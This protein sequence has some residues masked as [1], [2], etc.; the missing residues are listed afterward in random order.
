MR[1][2]LLNLYLAR[3]P[4]YLLFLFTAGWV[5]GQSSPVSVLTVNNGLSSGTVEC[6]LY[7]SRG[8]IWLG[9]RA[10]L[11]R[12]D[13]R[14]VVKYLPQAQDTHAI[15]SLAILRIQEDRKGRLFILGDAGLEMFD[16]VS[17]TFRFICGYTSSPPQFHCEL[18]ILDSLDIG[19]VT[20]IAPCEAV[21]FSLTSL[22][23]FR[24]STQIPQAVKNILANWW[25][26]KNPTQVSFPF[27]GQLHRRNLAKPLPDGNDHAYICF[28]HFNW[29]VSSPESDG[30]YKFSLD[31]DTATWIPFHPNLFPKTISTSRNQFF[32]VNDT[33]AMLYQANSG[34]FLVQ[35]NSGRILRQWDFRR[36]PATA[37]STACYFLFNDPA[38]R[39]WFSLLPYGVF[40]L[41]P[42]H[43]KFQ[44]LRSDAPGA[45]LHHGLPLSMITDHRGR[46][47]IG[48]YDGF[49]QAF[50]A[51]V[52]QVIYQTQ[53]RAPGIPDKPQSVFTLAEFPDG[54]IVANHSLKI[55]EFKPDKFSAEWLVPKSLIGKSLSGLAH[56]LERPVSSFYMG[57]PYAYQYTLLTANKARPFI[58]KGELP[59]NLAAFPVDERRFFVTIT[60]FYGL[61]EFSDDQTLQLELHKFPG[62]IKSAYRP[63]ASDSLWITSTR[64][65]YVY[66]LST[67]DM[68]QVDI[69]VWPSNYLYG[70]LPDE[71][72]NFWISTNAGIIRWHPHSGRWKCFD[73]LDGLQSNEFNTNCFA[74]LQD[75]SLAFGGPEGINIFDPA[76][77]RSRELPFH[78]Y[79]KGVNIHDKPVADFNPFADQF[80]VTLAPK[81]KELELEYGSTLHFDREDVHYYVQLVGADADWVDMGDKELAR[82]INLKPGN[83]VFRVKAVNADEV[84]SANVLKAGVRVKPTF[85]QTIWFLL[86][87]VLITAFFLYSLFRYRMRQVQ[88]LESIR[89]RISHDLHDDVG[90]TLGSIS[91][92]SEVAKSS[93]P[94]IR[95][96]V[97]EK[98]GDASREMLEKLNDIVWSINPENDSPE[99]LASRMRA[100]AAMVLNP[101]GIRFEMHTSIHQHEN[102]SM[103]TRRNLFLIFKEA[104]YNAAKYSGAQSVHI[105]LITEPGKIRMEIGDDGRGFD[106]G[107]KAAYNGN[108]LRSMEERARDLGAVLEINSL[109]SKGT[110]IVLR[111]V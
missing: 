97:L 77:F 104:V 58:A 105:R 46:L 69:P 1:E 80:S 111:Q 11:H 28:D 60:D 79:L 41:D 21:A 49:I 76:Y 72:G 35:K 7:D 24:D 29:W 10:G 8:F 99:K 75:G 92:Y 78:V 70:L 4:A 40:V 54:S 107:V 38:G 34:M 3:V 9:T 85:F 27:G 42:F 56:T 14:N 90:S 22:Q 32:P 108:G 36:D 110:R 109:P 55:R 98:I 67:K 96:D 23:L 44:S 50:N 2:H 43:R 87:C 64:G 83:Y 45:L 84:W 18:V 57:D 59:P 81:D 73:V 33:L 13:G 39:V 62:F 63:P 12:Y 20:E 31:R 106:P 88:K 89:N 37:K 25:I 103:D 102:L 68:T 6:G 15:R 52:N 53:Y 95:S 17:N 101:K 61:M 51:G 86:T 48:F 26:H 30:I 65:L 91:I 5:S 93:D 94:S 66:R 16:P 19:I 82:Y 74:R 71:E 47:W 100:Y